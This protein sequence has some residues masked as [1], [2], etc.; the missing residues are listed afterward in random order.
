VGEVHGEPVLAVHGGVVERVVR[1]DNPNGG[2][3]VRLL[4][5]G[6]TVVT[7]YMHLDEVEQAL[8]PGVHVRAGEVLGTVGETGVE[9]SGPHLH[10]TV[11]TRAHENAPEVYIDPEP[12][13]TLWPLYNR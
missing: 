2:R 5:K 7:Q 11:A 4:H 8:R 3:Y 12:L 13:L 6:G 9:H 10:F 1:D